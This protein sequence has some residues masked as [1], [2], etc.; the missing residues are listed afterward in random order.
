MGQGGT[1]LG[2]QLS[3]G[4]RGQKLKKNPEKHMLKTATIN[5]YEKN[6]D[7]ANG[8]GQKTEKKFPQITQISWFEGIGVKTNFAMNLD[9]KV[10]F[11][12]QNQND[13]GRL[14]F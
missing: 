2:C 5:K 14:D 8:H 10:A 9:P 12:F 1:H 13:W 11:V 3:Q 6:A 4:G 7:F